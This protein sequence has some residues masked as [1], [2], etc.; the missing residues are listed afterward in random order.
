MSYVMLVL[1]LWFLLGTVIVPYY[2]L[3]KNNNSLLK[4]PR[5]YL[6]E[7]FLVICGGAVSWLTIIS[8][9]TGDAIVANWWF[10]LA[11]MIGHAA[12]IYGV[13]TNFFRI[14]KMHSTGLSIIVALLSNFAVPLLAFIIATGG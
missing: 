6:Y 13:T 2:S 11:L 5:W 8:T 1:G 12:A 7:L 10:I 9:F 14:S 3:R 4:S